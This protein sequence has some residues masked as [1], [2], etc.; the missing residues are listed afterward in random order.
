VLIASFPAMV[1]F[2]L[3]LGALFWVERR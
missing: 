1:A 3:A 2:A